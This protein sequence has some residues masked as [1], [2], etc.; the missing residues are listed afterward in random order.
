MKIW[1]DAN[2]VTLP[3]NSNLLDKMQKTIYQYVSKT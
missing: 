1:V 2:T 3:L